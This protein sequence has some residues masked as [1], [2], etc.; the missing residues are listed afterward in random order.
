MSQL[1]KKDT[2]R[3]RPREFNIAGSIIPEEHYYV[4]LTP[5]LKKLLSLV[6]KRSYF[7]INRPRQCGKTTALNFLAQGLQV[8][9]KYVPAL[10]S[11]ESFTQRPD[12]PEAEFYRNVAKRIADELSHAGDGALAANE[13]A[14]EINSR[15]D[16]LIG[17]AKS[18]KAASWFC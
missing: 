10:I 9:G 18:A 15:D 17:C 14:P 5:Q 3:P 11:F 4:D 13:P 8:T 7:V 16:F 1:S 6:A 2:A 12:L